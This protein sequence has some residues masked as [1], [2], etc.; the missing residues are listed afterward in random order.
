M[1]HTNKLAGFL[2]CDNLS[3]F[4]DS[5]SHLLISQLVA[6]LRNNNGTL[7]F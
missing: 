2:N 3:F 5:T 4:L 6:V 7:R 1:K